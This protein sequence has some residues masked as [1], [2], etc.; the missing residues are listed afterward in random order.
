MTEK[1]KEY[2][3]K[4]RQTEKRRAYMKE[5]NKKY[6]E[7][8]K[9]YYKEKSKEYQQSEKRKIYNKKHYAE[10]KEQF[11]QYSKKYYQ[12]HKTELNKRNNEY[13]KQRR[14]NDP[15]YKMKSA[16]RNLLN[17]VFSQRIGIKKR[18]HTEEILGCTIE[19]FIKYIQSKFQEGMTL[20]NHGEWHIDH[21]IPIS[22]AKTED[23]VLKLNHYTNLQ[24]LWA[25]DNL[26]KGSK[27]TDTQ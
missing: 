23:E 3:R 20:E 5:Y 21:I 15:V 25:E 4:Y 13:K 14:N 7:Q 18:H 16:I 9:E 17:C 6:R 27:I 19:E 22:S 11:N 8:H 12:E 10:K 24:P 26:K 1:R 2:E